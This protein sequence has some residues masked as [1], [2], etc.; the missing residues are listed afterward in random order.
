MAD[1]ISRLKLESGEF[2]SKI[3]RASQE[4]TAYSAHCRKMG[5][6]MGYANKDAKEFAKSLGS[7]Q[8]TATT[9]RGKVSELS[10]AFVNLKAMYNQMTDAEKQGQFGKNLAASLDQLK[11]RTQQAKQELSDITKELNG[12]NSIG[13]NAGGLFSS[14]KLSGMLQ[15]FG[16]NL[17]TKGFELVAG[18]AA[19]FASE[20][21]N[22]IQQGIELA[23]QGEGVRI[24]FGRLGRGDLLD[25]LREATHGTVSDLELMKQAIK[26]ENFKLP[27]DDLANYLAF[28]Q[29][30]AK[31]TGESIDYLVN[32]I[33]TGLGRQSKQILDN[34]GI[35]AA[36]LT[37]RMNEGADMTKAVSD[38]IREEMSKAGGYVETAADRSARATADLQNKMEELGRTFQPIQEAGVS[39]FN[40]MVTAAIDALNKMRPFFD[41]FTEAGRIRQQK[42]SRGGDSR[43]NQ[44]LS[45]LKVARAA[46]SDYY[47]QSSYN[48]TVQDYQKQLRDLN[49]KIAAYGKPKDS[50]ESGNVQR[51]K[52]ERDA[53]Q[54]LFNAYQEGAKQYLHPV[55]VEINTDKSIKGVDDLK[56]KLKE[57]EAQRQKA[58]LAGDNELVENLTKQIN[59]TKQN[60]GYLDPNALKTGSTKVNKDEFTEVIGLIGNA[61]ERVSDLQKQISESWDN[62]EIARLR[63]ELKEAQNELDVLQGKLPKDTVAEITIK[64]DTTEALQKLENIDGVSIDP[65]TM[66]VTADTTEALQRVQKLVA[67]MN[68]TIVEVKVVPDVT[69]EDIERSLRQ[70]YGKPIEVPVV[71]KTTG[72]AIEQEIRVKLAEQN[73]D[74]DMQTLRTLLETQIKNGIEGIEI[75]SDT[76]AQAIMGEG[77]DIPDEYWSNL[78]DQIN[79]KLKDLGIDPINIDFSTG[80]E[81]GKKRK[82]GPMDDTK[83]VVSGLN[84]VASGLQQMG[85]ELPEGVN[86]VLGVVNGLMTII[87]GITS[88][89]SATEVPAQIA[90]TAALWAL[91]EAMWANT[92]FGFSGGGIVGFAKGGLI[93]KAAGGMMIPGN[94]YSGD[95]LRMPV[96]GGRG[97]IGVNSGELIL[98]RSQQF[99]LASQLQGNGMQGLNLT[100]TIRGEQIRLALNNNSRRR[101]RGE[102]VTSK[103]VK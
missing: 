30:K 18:A 38:I 78:Q 19:N 8:T 41:M 68:G 37:K 17:M 51:L 34:L 2:D 88:I 14:D 79:E 102:Y 58:V 7:M 91:T 4:L 44:Q 70:Q 48:S 13:G 54:Q 12:A 80:K 63:K 3:K 64:A 1:I 28:A 66:T 46:G 92:F 59:E 27:L 101:G 53:V 29:Q 95:N 76:L 42:E 100:A 25:G 71:P 52:E 94:S 40:N 45:K 33:V 39:M 72:E 5:L 23:K 9:A 61:Q 85:I 36:E 35:S 93:G 67:E 16:G 86:Q 77:I 20:I 50:I 87:G 62:N 43:V 75:P 74:A 98:N 11:I 84:Q 81:E 10:D 22:C 15:V 96:D 49:F 99:N 83:K 21:Q 60:I 26:F 103:N 32:S 6:E 90:N 47:V 56:K 24:A 57:L 97:W 82:G 89:I 73:M 55:D 69:D 65:K 31:D